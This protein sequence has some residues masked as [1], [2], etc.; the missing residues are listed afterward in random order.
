MTRVLLTERACHA[1]NVTAGSS[2]RKLQ[3]WRFGTDKAAA[4]RTQVAEIMNVAVP[5][6]VG[7][8][9]AAGG[10]ANGVQIKRRNRFE[11]VDRYKIRHG[12]LPGRRDGRRA[13]VGPTQSRSQFPSLHDSFQSTVECLIPT[14]PDKCRTEEIS[15]FR[16]RQILLHR[17]AFV[18]PDR[19]RVPGRIKLVYFISLVEHRW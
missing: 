8:V 17:F 3:R 19:E 1:S 7:H 4:A 14:A 16:I 11:I 2:R 18:Q 13:R 9:R 5:A 12:P 15:S 10:F 6:N